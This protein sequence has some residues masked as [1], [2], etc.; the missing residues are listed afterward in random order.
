MALTQK[1]LLGNRGENKACSYLKKQGYKI[2]E[3]N[4]RTPFGEV[5]IIAEREDVVAFIEVKTRSTD[6]FGQPNEAVNKDKQ[7]RYVQSAN[8]YFASGDPDVTVR[9]DII[10]IYK[11][12]I[13]HIINAFY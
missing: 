8:Y 10:E 6:K 3:R 2:L 1:K 5:D 9:F 4:Y 7:R 12:E 11:G 13:N